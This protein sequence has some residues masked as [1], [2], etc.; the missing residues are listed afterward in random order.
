MCVY[1][2]VFILITNVQANT[3][4]QDLLAIVIKDNERF[5]LHFFDAIE[6]FA[7]HIYEFALPARARYRDQGLMEVKLS[8]IDDAW[9]A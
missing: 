1:P 2:C 7:T 9:D 6:L 8:V 4:D 5:A 3:I